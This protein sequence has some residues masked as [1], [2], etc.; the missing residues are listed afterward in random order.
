MWKPWLRREPK[1]TSNSFGVSE[2]HFTDCHFLTMSR[3]PSWILGFSWFAC[4]LSVHRRPAT[5]LSKG[6]K[7]GTAPL[8]TQPKDD[9]GLLEVRFQIRYL[10]TAP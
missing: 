2:L 7:L 8:L 6:S 4:A 5:V 10:G 3:R 1:S 9:M